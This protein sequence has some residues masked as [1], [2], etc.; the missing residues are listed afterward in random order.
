MSGRLS[1]LVPVL[2]SIVAGAVAVRRSQREWRQV[3]PATSSPVDASPA[4]LA[5]P[6]TAVPAT[7]PAGE[8]EPGPTLADP[9]DDEPIPPQKGGGPGPDSPLELGPRDWKESARRAAKEFKDDRATLTSAGMAFYWFLSIFPA[10]VAFIGLLGL[11][12]AS[13]GAR[14]SIVEVVEQ[15]LPGEAARVLSDTV[16]TAGDS[17]GSVVAT[18]LGVILALW[19]A[20]AGMVGLQMGL[21]VAYD[22]KTDRKFVKKRLLAFELMLAMLVLGGA[23]TALIVFGAPLG[24]ALRDNLPFGSAFVVLWTIT[25]WVLGLAALT[26]LFATIYFLAPNR[27]TPK[28][29]WVSPGGLLAVGIW[30]L[31]SLGF[32][33]YV[34]NFGTYGET[35]G[36]LLAGVI[37]LLLW[38]YLTAL[39]MVAGGELNAELERQSAVKN[40]QVPAPETG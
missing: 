30:L 13:Q 5:R 17:D 33:V 14:D 25:R 1:R 34:A 38:L 36:A 27:G 24:D 28:W 15:A 10:M 22:V 20:S 23:A 21:N 11:V 9:S 8:L 19:S 40:G 39:A 4:V 12:D 2:A 32:S 16:R 18:L 7:R 29:V 35:Y 37:V 6:E 31:A 3:I 26:L